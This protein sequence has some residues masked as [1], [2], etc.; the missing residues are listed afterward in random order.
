MKKIFTVLIFSILISL[1]GS[2]GAKGQHKSSEKGEGSIGLGL[3]L[4]YGG[5][6][7]RFGYNV[8]NHTNLFAGLGYNFVGAAYNF[9]VRRSL[10]SKKQSEFYLMGM[11][12]TNAA[13]IITGSYNF[14]ESYQG[15]SIGAGLKI[16]SFS[17]EGSYWD[18]GILVPFRSSK[19]KDAVSSI[20]YNPFISEYV[21][22][23]PVLITIGYNFG[24]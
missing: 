19:Y 2:Q 23:W 3:G 14:K 6:G 13:I 1:L 17:K 15:P 22:A 5:I 10:P 9:G 4:P 24:L 16:N 21:E 20:N 7:S 18:L 12:G 11:Y 8:I